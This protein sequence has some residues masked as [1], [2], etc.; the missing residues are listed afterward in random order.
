MNVGILGLG[1]IGGSMA[2]AFSKAGHTVYAAD[3][4]AQILSF[5][6]LAG[7]VHGILNPDTIP[8]CDLILLA[9][10]PGG[11]IRWLE[12]NAPIVGKNTLV[13]DLCG[14][15][16]EICSHCFPLADKYGFTF[17]G[18]HPMAGSHNT[19]F[20]ASRSNLFQGAPMVLVPAKFDDIQLLQRV[21]DALEP[22]NFGSFSVCISGTVI[23]V[24]LYVVVGQVAAP[25]GSNAISCSQRDQDLDLLFQKDLLGKLLGE[26][27]AGTVFANGDLALGAAEGN[28]NRVYVNVGTAVSNGTE[29]ASPVGIGAKHSRL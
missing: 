13:M 17:V 18:G 15:K 6:E 14:V 25:G 2:R 8:A 5:A 19:G 3:Q 28:V 22:C 11:C 20:K 10:Y 23:A 29:N 12:E 1:L 16:E 7:V 4:D 27:Y 24:D 9:I 21:K 26:L